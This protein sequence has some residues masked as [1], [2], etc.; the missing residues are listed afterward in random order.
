MADPEVTPNRDPYKFLRDR[1][2][3]VGREMEDHRTERDVNI[4]ERALK[5]KK[6]NTVREKM[7]DKVINT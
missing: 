2:I 6:P 1:A 7:S 3:A 5:G 4:G